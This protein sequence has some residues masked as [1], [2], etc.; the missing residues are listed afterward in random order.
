MKVDPKV[1]VRVELVLKAA[2]PE[3]VK[4]P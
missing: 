2:D 1:D 4:P 3:P